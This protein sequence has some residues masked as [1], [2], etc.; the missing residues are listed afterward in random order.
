M[1]F[2][3]IEDLPASIHADILNSLTRG[4]DQTITDNVD[5]TVDE[6]KAYL[7][8]GR[9]DVDAIFNAEGNNRN[10]YILRLAIDILKFYIYVVGNPRKITQE[11]ADG[12]TRALETLSDIKLGNLNPVGLPTPPE[13]DPP[14]NSGNGAPV[15][16][17]SDK[18]MGTNW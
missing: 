15:Q 18:Q 7:N 9:Y 5:R 8:N 17:G 12:Y 2:I 14:A 11:V 1:A 4:I 10:K 3:T 16:W 13:A 6:M